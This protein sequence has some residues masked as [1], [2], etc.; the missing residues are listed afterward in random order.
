MK[1]HRIVGVCAEISSVQVATAVVLLAE[2]GTA[3]ANGAT[4]P[5][6]VINTK[7]FFM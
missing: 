6:T 4:I 7:D 1:N 5:K 2:A 3:N